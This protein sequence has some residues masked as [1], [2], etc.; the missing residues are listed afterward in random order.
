MPEALLAVATPSSIERPPLNVTWHSVDLRTGARGQQLQVQA[1]TAPSRILG[2]PTELELSV[3]L[4]DKGAEVPGWEAATLPGRVMVV[5]L[6][7]NE[8]PIWGGM[9]YRRV[10]NA[11]AWVAL[12]TVTL[13]AYL[14]R[15]YVQD[16]TYTFVSQTL[17]AAGVIG[18]ATTD[19][20][21][22]DV[23]AIASFQLR[24]R[25]YFDD[26]DKTVLSV[27]N[28]L[29]EIES[30]LEF[31]IDLEW[32]DDTRTVLSRIIRIAD[33]IGTPTT[34]PTAMFTMPGCVTDFTYVEDYSPENGANA[35]Q[36]I[37]SGEGDTRPESQWQK[38]V[39][40]GWVQYDKKITPSTSI[41]ETATLNLHARAEVLQTW[42]GMKEL[43][44]EAQA[45]AAPRIG[46]DWHLGDD[47]GVAL[48]CPR[49]PERMNADGAQ[50]PGYQAVVRAIG[51]ELDLEGR[52][53]KP[54]LLEADEVEVEA[55]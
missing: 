24:E 9:V 18:D 44:L 14:D 15:R 31:T 54:R 16:H 5:A 8:T 2:T 41:T 7:E 30:G 35:V 50:V 6:D 25:S 11:S 13:E 29:V 3:R 55:L 21:E 40:P 34:T 38:A 51:W 36:A 37:S 47:V 20:V 43:V 27:L 12:N 46:T 17:I 48:T 39:A 32:A 53:L 26:E 33:R 23:D 22:F 45:D 52:R 49:F 10:G 1:K 4:W 42:D 19:G 28:E